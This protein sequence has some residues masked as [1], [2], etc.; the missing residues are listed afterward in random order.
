MRMIVTGGAGFIGPHITELLLSDGHEV[1][2]I[3]DLTSGSRDNLPAGVRLHEADIRSPEIKKIIG[4]FKP[5]GFVHA[6]A[7]ISVRRSMEDPRFD[8]D[9]NVVGLINILQSF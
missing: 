2:V 5:E 8:T 6:A 1:Q 7:Q 4:D 9:V 3:D